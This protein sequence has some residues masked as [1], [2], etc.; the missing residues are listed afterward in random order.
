MKNV[1]IIVPFF[2]VEKYFRACLESLVNQDYENIQLIL[3]DDES[4]DKSLNIAKEFAQ[5]DSRICIL[6]QKNSGQAVAR[7]LGLDFLQSQLKLDFERNEGA[8][9]AFVGEGFRAW[10][11]AKFEFKNT[12]YLLFVDSDDVVEKSFVSECLKAIKDA[13]VLWFDYDFLCEIPFK[14][15][16]KSQMELFDL[17]E[18][19]ITAKKWLEVA[20]TKPLFWLTWQGMIDFKFLQKIKLRFVNG[21][22]YEDNCF[23]VL[24][25]SMAEKIAI[26]KKKLYHYR[27]RVN[28]T[29]NPEKRELSTHSYLYELYL[30]VGEDFEALKAHQWAKS[31]LLSV[32]YMSEFK[33]F[34]GE[35]REHFM[36]IFLDR[37]VACLFLEQDPLNLKQKLE[38]LKGEFEHY[39]LSGAECVRHEK[40]YKL[41]FIFLQNYKSFGGLKR[42]FKELKKSA[43]ECE[44]AWGE[45]TKNKAKFHFLHFDEDKNNAEILKIKRHYSYKVGKIMSFF[46]KFLN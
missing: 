2:N 32:L 18:G 38:A 1:S 3:I 23:G 27:I 33:G 28:S 41:G 24:L 45:F 9:C 37:A 13:N 11:N 10:Q 19:I 46:E 39:I 26:C 44:R 16:P 15:T 25:F 4:D 42:L 36:P 21:A 7:N 6:S 8:L 20:K 29:M 35:F 40:A 12:D 34:E 22:I 30:A 31:W 5:K 17:S 43:L 14:K